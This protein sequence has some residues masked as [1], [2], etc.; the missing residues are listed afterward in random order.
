MNVVCMF[1]QIYL[2]RIWQSAKAGDSRQILIRIVEI[3][4]HIV[5]ISQIA[6]D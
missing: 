4:N 6:S 1:F 3:I 2:F 5:L